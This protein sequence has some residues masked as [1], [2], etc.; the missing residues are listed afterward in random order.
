MKNELPDSCFNECLFVILGGTG[1]LT[2][3]KLIPA[4]YKLAADNKLCKFYIVLVSNISTSVP[5]IFSLAKPFVSKLDEKIWGKIQDKTTYFKM[6]FNDNTAYAQ[7]NKA[8]KIVENKNGLIGNRIFYFAT[9]PEHFEVISRNFANH[10]IVSNKKEVE[11]CCQE[12]WSRLVYEKPFGFDLNSAKNINK[13]IT[14]IFDER[15]IYR[16]DHYLGKELVGNIA[17]LRFTNRVF[18][19]LWN[20]QHIESVAINISEDI[21]VGMRGAFYDSYGVLK[22]M[23]QSHILQILALVAM[24]TPKKL[25]ADFIR[26][27][28]ADVL[29][30][31]EV[32]KVVLGQYQG[33]LQEK[34]VKPE[35]KTETFA[36][37]RVKIKN[38]RWDGVPFYLKTGKF[39]GKKQ[40][41]VEIT[42][43]Q[44]SCLLNYCP[45][46]PNSL[47]I[48]IQPDEGFYLGLNVKMPGVADQVTP[49]SMDFCHS[50]LFGPNT[51]EAYEILL[52]DV[53]KGD[54]AAFVRSDEVELSWKILKQINLSKIKLFS[55]QKMSDGPV[56]QNE[57]YR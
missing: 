54:Q 50:C 18:E 30:N 32:E 22:D 8:L 55:Y 14:Q 38:K 25:T 53:I 27:A 44:V 9:M 43:K 15:Q 7:L 36:A 31:V 51:P 39:L 49:V 24:E 20:N 3:R 10:R 34:D 23:V 13:Y 26:D 47:V 11:A 4:I 41:F 28:K 57:V 37:L 29:K 56:E 12:P 21:G 52:T 42:F 2:K 6:D 48:K 19:P 16:I 35:S 17:L 33:Y 1:D 40:A 46:K 5:E 45:S